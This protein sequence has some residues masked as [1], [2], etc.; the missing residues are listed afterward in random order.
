MN[1]YAYQEEGVVRLSAILER[2]RRAYLADGMGLG[3]TAQALVVASRLGARRVCAIAPASAVE[4]WRREQRAWYPEC[5]T[6]AAVSYASRKL[7]GGLVR[8]EDWDF[9]ILDEAHYAK[10][11]RAKR[12]KAALRAASDAPLALLLSGTPMPN[13]PRELFAP[14]KYLWPDM[15][16]PAFRT[17]QRWT[18]YFCRYALTAWGPKITGVRNGRVL[19]RMIDQIMVRRKLEDVALDLPPLRVTMHTL[20]KDAE[21]A[22][23]LEETGVDGA[24]LANAIE[25]EKVREDPSTSRLRRL[26]GE[27]KAPLIAQILAEELDNRAYQKVV[28]LYYHKAAGR[29]LR[30]QLSPYGVVGFDGSTPQS[31]RQAAIDAFTEDSD[32]RVFCAQQTSAGEGINL[33]VASEIVLVEP[34]WSPDQNRQAIKRIHRVGS[35][36][37]CRARIFGVAGTIDQSV[38]ETQTRKI[39][40]QREVGL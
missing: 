3:K 1:L 38:M 24:A 33:Q 22:R 15:L 11:P 26:M 2:R 27:Y 16:R 39:H 34:A 25:A 14:F 40:H 13:D 18:N 7:H 4:N 17:Q 19:R 21:F 12:T 23:A 28:V 37:P 10:N 5:Q 36:H 31:Q 30:E 32:V 29:L 20:P 8:G 6:F 9:V 35:E